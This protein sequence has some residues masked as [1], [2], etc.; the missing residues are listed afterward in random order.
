MRYCIVQKT[1]P[2]VWIPYQPG[3]VQIS[4]SDK[5]MSSVLK[6]SMF[7]KGSGAFFETR[8][9]LFSL[10]IHKANSLKGT[11]Q[12]CALYVCKTAVKQ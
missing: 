12:D 10:Y 1:T 3:T 2:P 5:V 8:Y 6:C 4:L 9:N 11:I 7:Q